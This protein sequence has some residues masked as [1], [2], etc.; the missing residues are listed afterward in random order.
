MLFKIIHSRKPLNKFKMNFI[1]RFVY[2][3]TKVVPQYMLMMTSMLCYCYQRLL[4][5]RYNDDCKLTLYY[6]D[7]FGY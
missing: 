4:I 5:T 6:A 7:L 1:I 3:D 2:Y